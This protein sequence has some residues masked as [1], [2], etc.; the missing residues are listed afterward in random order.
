MSVELRPHCGINIVTKQEQ[1]FEQYLVF[2]GHPDKME[3]V[4]LIGWEPHHKLIFTKTIDPI[5]QERISRE[6][7]V[8]LERELE[9]TNAPDIDLDQTLPPEE[10][11]FNEFNESDL[12]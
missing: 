4:G 12:I 11:P 2:D 1:C 7:A 9:I 8:L 5:R 10:N 3:R 6:V